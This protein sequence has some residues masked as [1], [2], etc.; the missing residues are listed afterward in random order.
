MFKEDTIRNVQ[1][2]YRQK[3]SNKI[4]SEMFK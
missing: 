1:R 4:P 3:C 2:R